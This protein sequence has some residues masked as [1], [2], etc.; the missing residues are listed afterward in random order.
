M[1]QFAKRIL[2]WALATLSGALMAAGYEPWKMASLAWIAW[3]PLISQLL[4]IEPDA[5]CARP[6]LYGFVAG[7]VFWLCTIFWLVHVSYPAMPALAAYLALFTG[8]WAWWMSLIR[9]RWKAVAGV[10]HILL[11]ALGACGWVALEWLRGW[12]LGGFPW[13]F[14]AVSQ[15]RNLA[16]IQVVEWT[17]VHGLSFVILFFNISLWLTWRRLKIERFSARSWRYEFSAAVFLVAFCLYVGMRCLGQF[18]LAGAHA[19]RMWKPAS[20]S[21][22]QPNIPQNAKYE[23]MKRDDQRRI[24]EQLTLTAAATKPDLILWPETALVDGPLYDVE[25]R[26]WLQQIAARAKIPILLGTLDATKEKATVTREDR[27]R[28][29]YYNAAILIHPDGTFERPY[30]KIHLVPFGEYVPFEK[31]IPWMRKLTPIPG[32]FDSGGEPVL[33][34]A[35]SRKLGI[36]ICFED[37]LPSL[38]RELVRKGADVIVN[39]TNDAWFQDS[40][41]AA[42]HLANSVFRTIETRRPLVRCTNNGVTAMI[43]TMGEIQ[44]TQLKPF[45]RGF[46]TAPL[47]CRW[48]S[49]PTW[50]VR[51]GDWF[52][53]MCLGFCLLAFLSRWTRFRS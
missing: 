27:W 6:F 22:I 5:S 45:T 17:G 18:Q 36:V 30:H 43:S 48:N 2:P 49:S 38:S 46:W 39:L 35:A 23:A 21:L 3:L 42:Q 10:S 8:V 7:L 19:E 9:R 33:I 28:V 14:A 37:T 15:Y 50:S 26:M 32:S 1:K 51:F 13:N 31:Q 24:L 44:Y 40:P 47:D 20:F 53:R 12:L 52:P 16:L 11:A 41:A 4:P 34:Q 25:S 29:S